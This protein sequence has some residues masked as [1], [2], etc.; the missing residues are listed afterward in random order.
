MA[1]AMKNKLVAILKDDKFRYFHLTDDCD[2]LDAADRA[3][4]SRWVEDCANDPIWEEIVADAREY[5]AEPHNAIHSTLIVRALQARRYAERVRAGYD[6]ILRERQKERARLLEL[7]EKSDDL[8]RYYQE[9]EKYSG[10]AGFFQRF[11]EWSVQPEHE[12]VPRTESPS[13][14]VQQLRGLHEREAQLLR[15]RA[16]RE[17]KPTTF[18]SRKKRKRHIM[19][20]IHMMSVAIDE[21]CGKQHRHAVAILTNVAFNSSVGTQDVRKAL[22]SNTWGAGAE[23]VAH[24]RQIKRNERASPIRRVMK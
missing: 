2:R 15:Q 7:A 19:A 4:L 9:I 17:P 6:P 23:R 22:N 10:I 18:I 16:K 24:S 12:A 13:L 21:T 20:F 5:D 8:A 14:R 1:S 11:L 3:F